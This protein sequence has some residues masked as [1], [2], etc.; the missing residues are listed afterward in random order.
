M[1]CDD[2]HKNEANIHIT[3]ISSEGKIDKHL[4]E[5]CAAKYG[6]FPPPGAKDFTVNDFLKGIF[7]KPVEE[8]E[9]PPPTGLVCPNCGMTFEDFAHSGKI[10]CS[11]C[12][13]TFRRQI[14][15][16]LTR[17]HGASA[18]SGKIPRSSGGALVA[19]REVE[20][21]KE[22]LNNAVKNEEYE[23]A[24][25]YRDE[26]RALEKKMSERARAKKEATG[27]AGE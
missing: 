23:N 16:L 1:L 18:H 22:K 9:T 17:I 21:L 8:Q 7:G 4:C 6:D 24:A 26:I 12:Y 10:G 14:T 19:R 5:A 3:Q 20:I 15:P 11:V 13:D 27:D 25:K 2:C